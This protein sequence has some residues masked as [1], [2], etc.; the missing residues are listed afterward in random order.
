M[1][2]NRK[3]RRPQRQPRRP[4][5]RARRPRPQRRSS[6]RPTTVRERNTMRCLI[7]ALVVLLL[8]QVTRNS[9]AGGPASPQRATPHAPSISAP[10]IPPAPTAVAPNADA[11][12]AVSGGELPVC[13]DGTG[14]FAPDVFATQQAALRF[15]ARQVIESLHAAPAGDKTSSEKRKRIII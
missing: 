13:P 10:R 15:A 6:Q 7:L 1:C 14:P 12:E 11:A 3:P 2:V 5:H 4:Q 9:Q 8:V